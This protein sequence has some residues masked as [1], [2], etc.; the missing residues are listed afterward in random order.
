[1][2]SEQERHIARYKD[3]QSFPIIL[4]KFIVI[5]N[6]LEPFELAKFC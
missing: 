2:S 6:C 3:L 4:I 1:M 5:S